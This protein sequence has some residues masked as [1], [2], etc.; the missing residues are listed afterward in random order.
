MKIQHDVSDLKT[1]IEKSD[2]E[3]KTYLFNLTKKTV[4]KVIRHYH[5]KRLDKFFNKKHVNS[6]KIT[7]DELYANK[8]SGEYS[9]INLLEDSHYYWL[10]EAFNLY[11]RI[12]NIQNANVI[13]LDEIECAA[14]DYLITYVNNFSIRNPNVEVKKKIGFDEKD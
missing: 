11:M 1:F 13:I 3:F 10:N 5:A 8:N 12:K 9:Y 14:Y 4:V 7:D 2:E 6:F